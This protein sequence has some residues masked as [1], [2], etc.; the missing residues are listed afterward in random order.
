MTAHSIIAL[1]PNR[2]NIL[3]YEG[4]NTGID[5]LNVPPE[6]LPAFQTHKSAV[7]RHPFRIEWRD[8]FPYALK[9]AVMRESFEFANFGAFCD[10]VGLHQGTAK[11]SIDKSLLPEYRGRKYLDFR[12]RAPEFIA[13]SM[14]MARLRE[15]LAPAAKGTVTGYRC[16]REDRERR[17]HNHIRI[18]LQ[19][20][21]ESLKKSEKRLESYLSQRRKLPVIKG[22]ERI[23][24]RLCETYGITERYQLGYFSFVPVTHFTPPSGI[25]VRNVSGCYGIALL[26]LKDPE[27]YR[28]ILRGTP[29]TPMY[30]ACMR[31]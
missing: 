19:E 8:K 3:C 2:Y 28:H 4:A 27:M 13:A 6:Y 17:L 24:E 18:M 7:L 22:R 30:P 25:S 1:A 26:D 10:A 12:T 9:V 29:V 15:Y 16:Y 20:L 23:E 14:E 5:L 21:S 31:R 11:Y